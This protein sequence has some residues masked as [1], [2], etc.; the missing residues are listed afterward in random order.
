[1]HRDI[2]PAN[3]MISR[4]GHLKVL[5]FGLAKLMEASRITRSEHTLGTAY[6]IAPEMFLGNSVDHRADLWAAGVLFY[7]MLTGGLPFGESNVHR[8]MYAV[9][10]KDPT[11]LH[12]LNPDLPGELQ[13]II[14]KCLAKKPLNR[15]SSLKEM[16][17]DL[18][19][20]YN[21]L[22]GTAQGSLENRVADYLKQ[23]F[24]ADRQKA[25]EEKGRTR[26][27]SL[28]MR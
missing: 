5:D 16:I 6:Y 4:E 11:P 7:Q 15:Y 19:I 26:S 28:D 10:N 8:V 14:D 13:V 18:M 12:V 21:R 24:A 23:R 17:I 3:I 1:V 22:I 9:V 27:I 25:K 2:K 20:L